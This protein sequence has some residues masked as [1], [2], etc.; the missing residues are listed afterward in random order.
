M[1]ATKKDPVRADNV[2]GMPVEPGIETWMNVGP[3]LLHITKIGEY[4]K[5][6]SELIYGNRVFAI[7]PQERRLNQSQC[8]NSLDDPFT[9]GTFKPLRLLEDEPDT[10]TL[11]ANPNVLDDGAI[12]GLFKLTG[13][14][15]GQQLMA[16]T[17]PTAVDRLIE[18]AK[19]S[20]TGATVGQLEILQ[21]Y[22]KLL[23]GEKDEPQVE[24]GPEPLPK[25]VTPR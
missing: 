16:I 9:N 7:T 15:F 4:G 13:E 21:R 2:D 11:R 20:A 3:S 18:V 23:A 10:E 22:K 12:A 19:Q 14:P 6:E 1:V 25:P 5:R 17:N 8:F 24:A